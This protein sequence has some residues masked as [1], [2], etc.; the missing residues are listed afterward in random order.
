MI[1]LLSKLRKLFQKDQSTGSNLHLPKEEEQRFTLYLKDLKVGELS[2]EKGVW[3]FAYSEDFK[4]RSD[5]FYPIVGF[6][7]LN[8]VYKS[9]SLWPFFLIRIPGLGQPRVREIIKAEHLDINNEA[10]LLRR[11]GRKTIA[12]PYELT[13]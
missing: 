2:C 7:D 13:V 6:P 10:Q 12:N 8:K 9:K 3:T 11:F 5:E 4:A 1:G